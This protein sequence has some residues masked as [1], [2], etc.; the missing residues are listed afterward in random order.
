MAVERAGTKMGEKQI[1]QGLREFSEDMDWICEKQ[2]T[3]R[4]KFT[5]K[6]IAVIGRQVID[7]DSELET[8][9]RKLKEK[10]GIQARFR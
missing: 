10:G 1:L 5:N 7:S 4:K 8:L 6:Y 2:A 9:L 3:L